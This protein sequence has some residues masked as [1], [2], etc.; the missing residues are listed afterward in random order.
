MWY[1]Y[2]GISILDEISFNHMQYYV[3]Y[4]ASNQSDD[5]VFNE[6]ISIPEWMFEE[7]IENDNIKDNDVDEETEDNGSTTSITNNNGD[8]ISSNTCKTTI[9][10]DN[11]SKNDDDDNT[12]A[13]ATISETSS[14]III[15]REM[16]LTEDSET[17]EAEAGI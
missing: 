7:P 9:S 2:Y 3:E 17:Y 15:D 10:S 8:T 6:L 4:K 11:I 12:V 5:D 16:T 14:D 13:A 1:Q